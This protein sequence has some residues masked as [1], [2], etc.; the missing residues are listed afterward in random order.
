MSKAEQHLMQDAIDVLRRVA[1]FFE[2]SNA[3]LGNDARDVVRRFE[4][5]SSANGGSNG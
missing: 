3:P 2:Y 4:E 5:L 1:T